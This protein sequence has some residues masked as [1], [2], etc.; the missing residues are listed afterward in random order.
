MKKK[1]FIKIICKYFQVNRKIIFLISPTVD[2]N[3]IMNVPFDFMT[4]LNFL[5]AY[6]GLFLGLGVL[7]FFELFSD[8]VSFWK[9][10]KFDF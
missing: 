5:G 1:L 6:V 8:K 10:Y 7:Q 9:K 2:I 4:V 3:H